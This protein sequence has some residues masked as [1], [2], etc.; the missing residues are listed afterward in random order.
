MFLHDFLK[1]GIGFAN[2]MSLSTYSCH[3]K[4]AY[5]YKFTVSRVRDIY[6]GE[7]DFG[8]SLCL[9]PKILKYEYDDKQE[10]NNETHHQTYKH[11][12]NGDGDIKLL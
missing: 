3:W 2:T 4:S 6:K 12:G 11:F 9:Q 10:S 7:P 5:Q 8:S 1:Q